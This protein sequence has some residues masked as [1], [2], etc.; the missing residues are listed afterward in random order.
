MEPGI[1]YCTAYSRDFAF[2]ALHD[3]YIYRLTRS[4]IANPEYDQGDMRKAFLHTLASS[5]YTT[6]PLLVVMVLPVWEDTPWYSATIQSHLNLE[7]LIKI[8]KGHICD[9]SPLI[10]KQT[11]TEPLYRRL[12]GQSHLS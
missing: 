12:S 9:L 5:T 7:T 10:N 1:T 11:A 6:T 2:D 4:C 3:A 8:P